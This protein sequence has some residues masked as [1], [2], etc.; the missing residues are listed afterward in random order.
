[1]SLSVLYLHVYVF[2]GIHQFAVTYLLLM[3]FCWISVS[4]W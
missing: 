2:E 1:M 3:H 4:K